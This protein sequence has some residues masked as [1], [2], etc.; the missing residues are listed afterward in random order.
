MYNDA[1][2]ERVCKTR[3]NICAY[4]QTDYADFEKD[5]VR[6]GP[7]P[8][9]SDSLIRQHECC[10]ARVGKEHHGDFNTIVMF[11][12]MKRVKFLAIKIH[13]D[14]SECAGDN[15]VISC[16]RYVLIFDSKVPHGLATA[17]RSVISEIMHVPDP[18]PL[19]FANP[20][21]ELSVLLD[22]FS[23]SKDGA[24]IRY[25]SKRNVLSMFH[26]VEQLRQFIMA[27][28]YTDWERADEIL[29]ADKPV[30]ASRLR[31]QVRI[32]TMNCITGEVFTSHHV[33]D[34]PEWWTQAPTAMLE[35]RKVVICMWQ[36]NCLLANLT[37][38]KQNYLVWINPEQIHR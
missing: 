8:V 34:T 2:Y 33:Y 9:S 5:L 19:Y 4:I 38:S 22:S 35:A 7:D 6:S 20:Y 36:H 12:A 16:V 27:E 14:S 21:C 1:S 29:A 11:A 17:D 25:Q 31:E 3:R 30:E 10:S 15:E 26:P 37:Y 24:E 13:E 18:E 28:S 23:Q 32:R